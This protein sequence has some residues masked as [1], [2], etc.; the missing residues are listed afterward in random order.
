MNSGKIAFFAS[1][2]CAFLAVARTRAYW[3]SCIGAVFGAVLLSQ[4]P[5]PLTDPGAA[6]VDGCA[7]LLLL[8]ILLHGI[9]VIQ[10]APAREAL[11]TS[12]ASGITLT[13]SWI[14]LLVATTGVLVVSVMSQL[15]AQEALG[16]ARVDLASESAISALGDALSLLAH[17]LLVACVTLAWATALSLW[18]SA[19]TASLALLLVAASGWIL[20]RFAQQFPPL[21]V[22][23]DLAALSPVGNALQGPPEAQLVL[24]ALVHASV[25]LAASQTLISVAAGRG[26]RR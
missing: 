21:M 11:R 17:A 22:L 12:P 6:F 16:I 4:L 25:P 2:R 14:G 20:P 18:L 19:Q 23:P 9:L 10:L 3:L 5:L 8:L 7:S 26:V 15:I 24:Y 13:A 1:V